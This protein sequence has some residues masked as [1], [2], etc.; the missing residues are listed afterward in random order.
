MAGMD[1]QTARVDDGGVRHKRYSRFRLRWLLLLFIPVSIALAIYSREEMQRRRISKAFDR[2]NRVGF[3]A[4]FATNGDCILYA[5][6]GNITDDDLMAL[7]PVASGE[8][9]LGNHKVIRIDLC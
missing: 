1:D 5:K 6:N 2:F 7:L 4:N 3:D 9:S 8:A